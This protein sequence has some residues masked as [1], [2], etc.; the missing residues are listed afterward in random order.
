MLVWAACCATCLGTHV[1][2]AH[3]D[4]ELV[5][6]HIS[7]PASWTA[8][9]ASIGLYR[10]QEPVQSC[11]SSASGL[12][13]A[14]C[15]GF[16]ALSETL[17]RMVAGLHQA[18]ILAVQREVNLAVLGSQLRALQALLLTAPYHRLPASLPSS[19][20]EVLIVP[21]APHRAL[22]QTNAWLQPPLHAQPPIPAKRAGGRML[23]R[24]QH[25]CLSSVRM[26]LWI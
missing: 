13:H 6:T 20:A 25:A 12:K 16:T 9:H 5:C 17:G 26:P 11:S 15:R 21:L 14:G 24:A 1:E 10:A 18:F 22:Q 2:V 7:Q 3:I 8:Q 23:G 19:A 4:K